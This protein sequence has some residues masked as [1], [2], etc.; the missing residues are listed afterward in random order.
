M[1][2]KTTNITEKMINDI[3]NEFS[4]FV[5]KSHAMVQEIFYLRNAIEELKQRDEE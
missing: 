1:I 3:L 4:N 2:M 5:D